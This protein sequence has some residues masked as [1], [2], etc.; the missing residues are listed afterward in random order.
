MLARK[1]MVLGLV[2]GAFLARFAAAAEI[3]KHPI[4]PL[5][6]AVYGFAVAEYCGLLTP[7]VA[8]GFHLERD[9]IV[10]RDGITPE[11]ERADRI[12]AVMAADWQY[13][14]HGLGGYRGWCRSEGLAA[15]Y[16]FL[17]FREAMLGK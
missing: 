12:A 11:R 7:D 17:R 16:R 14:D 3:Q 13:G 6:E 10:A 4:G 8:E 5:Q 1:G 9:W 15:A 2:T